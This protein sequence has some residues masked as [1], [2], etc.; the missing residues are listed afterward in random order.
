MWNCQ[1]VHTL[2]LLCN[3]GHT[4]SKA[5]CICGDFNDLKTDSILHLSSKLKQV[6]TQPTR[7]NPPAILDQI[8]TDLHSYYQTPVCDVPL[9]VD[10]DKIGSD[11]DHFMVQFE[12]LT[13]IN[14]HAIAVT[15][16]IECRPLTDQGFKIMEQ[17]L[18]SF[19]WEFLEN[20]DDPDNQMKTF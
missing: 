20:D 11:S 15:K 9:Q 10:D 19:D 18:E 3:L 2:N 12:P 5:W 4:I 13:T 7:Q 16:K 1:L 14:N 17:V 6:V 8:I